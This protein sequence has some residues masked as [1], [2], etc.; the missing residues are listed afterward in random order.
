M[1]LKINE[2]ILPEQITFNYEE[3][4]QELTEKVSHYETLVYTD[5][6]IKEAKADKAN[7]NKLKKALN[8]ER[9]RREKEYMVPFNA[10][11]A[12]INE[13]IGIIDKPVAVIDKQVKEYEEK[14]K[15]DKLK[16]IRDLWCNM[17]VIDG[18]LTFA[19]IFNEKWLNA[20]VSMKTIQTEMEEGIKKFNDDMVTLANLPEFGFEAVEVYKSTLDVNKAI[21]EAHRMS[22]MA[23]AKAAHEAEIKAREEEEAKAAE[24]ARL[25]AEEAQKKQFEQPAVEEIAAPAPEAVETI[26]AAQHPESEIGKAIESTERQAF[27]SAVNTPAS[28]PDRM[29]VS[30]KALLTT[31]DALA[32]K[33]FFESRNIEFEA[34]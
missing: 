2:V 29:W 4:K 25:A 5:D 20:S 16:A 9:I 31:E 8:D 13:I 12:Q 21:S 6:Q 18:R 19:L 23:K 30:F 10:F 27:E 24:Q 3:L 7:L 15:Q 34:I 22:E 26:E 32:L 11:K 28:E 1:E 17:E 33:D 14:Q